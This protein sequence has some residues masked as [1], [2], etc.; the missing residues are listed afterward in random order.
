[1]S[2]LYM[3]CSISLLVLAVSCGGTSSGD[4]KVTIGFDSS[5]MPS[6]DGVYVS[7]ASTVP[8]DV[9]KI[10]I[11]VSDSSETELY[12]FKTI[13]VAELDSDSSVTI[14][15]KAGAARVFTVIGRDEVGT[16]KYS[17]SSDPI[18]LREGESVELIL[19]MKAVLQDAVVPITLLVEEG[20]GASYVL[21]A[22]A[23]SI[24]AEVY[25]PYVLNG[26]VVM[27]SPLSGNYS[28]TGNS[29][30][31][32]AYPDTYQII[33]VRVMTNDSVVYATGGVIAAVGSSI[34][35][36][37]S[38]GSNPAVNIRMV[39]PGRLSVS[40]S[41]D[42]NSYTV[43]ETINGSDYTISSA[44]GLSGIGSQI[45]FTVPNGVEIWGK[46]SDASA[47]PDGI[48]AISRTVKISING[49]SAQTYLFDGSTYPYLRWEQIDLSY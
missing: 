39:K 32:S 11:T 3:L 43:V 1:M 16:A 33:M 6:G 8:G 37:L 19:A 26:E 13:N 38:S 5:K 2:K 36:R 29:F 4:S 20:T 25:V 18:D 15:V 14:D 22:Y 28:G 48:H 46:E 30:S 41:A 44:S 21:P 12:L 9:E 7:R 40:A 35:S 34:A 27:G 31:L 23:S 10:E 45:L 42:I 24:K 17:V 47:N 49:G